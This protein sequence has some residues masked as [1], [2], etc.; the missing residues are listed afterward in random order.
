MFIDNNEDN[1]K[2]AKDHDIAR[3]FENG[4]IING[5]NDSQLSWIEN[6]ININD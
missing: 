4:E 2:Y 6:Q 1:M 5:L 3:I